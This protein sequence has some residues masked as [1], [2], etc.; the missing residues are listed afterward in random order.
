MWTLVW[1]QWLTLDLSNGPN[2]LVVRLPS[3][4][5]GN[6]SSFRNAVF[7]S[8]YNSEWQTKSRNPAILRV[9]HHRQN[10]LD[11]TCSQIADYRMLI[12]VQQEHCTLQH[13]MEHSSLHK[14]YSL[15]V[16]VCVCVC[17]CVYFKSTYYVTIHGNSSAYRG[18]H[19]VLLC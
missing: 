7:S 3:L 14:F 11:S 15:H 2:R 1:V 6:R 8:I 9:I 5:D 12:L 13:K 18:V 17:V 19:I 16:C 4:E 10:P